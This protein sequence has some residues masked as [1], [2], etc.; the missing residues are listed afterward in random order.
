MLTIV[1]GMIIMMTLTMMITEN[2][3]AVRSLR[4]VATAIYR[5]S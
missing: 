1:N 4:C 5:K 3:I 2:M